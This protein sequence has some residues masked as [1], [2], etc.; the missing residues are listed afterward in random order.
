MYQLDEHATATSD[1]RLKSYLYSAAPVVVALFLV[2]GILS[3]PAA[4]PPTQAATQS[5]APVMISLAG[6]SMLATPPTVDEMNAAMAGGEHYKPL[7]LLVASMGLIDPPMAAIADV[8][9]NDK[10]AVLGVEVDGVG[11]AFL[12]SAMSHPVHV[13]SITTP[14]RPIAAA[15]CDMSNSVRVLTTDEGTDAIELGIGGLDVDHRM[16]LMYDGE[17]F[18]F[19]SKALP[20]QDHPFELTTLGAWKERFPESQI[21]V[22]SLSVE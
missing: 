20:L 5:Q 1:D 12:R 17:R 22:G 4:D 10:T 3:I 21:F 14:T 8:P 13:V 2:A 9:A 7:Q 15:Y 18:G 19:G 11:Y 6:P 16:V